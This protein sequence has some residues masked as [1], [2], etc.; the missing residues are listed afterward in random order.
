MMP[1][2]RAL[3]DFAAWWCQLWAE[4]LGKSATVG[5]T[6]VTALGATDQHS[7]IQL[8]NEG[9]N[10]KFVLFV[11]P[12]RFRGDPTIPSLFPGEA[13]CS[14]LEGKKLSTVMHALRNGTEEALTAN[15]RPNATVSIPEVNARTLGALLYTFEM[16]TAIAGALYGVNPFDQPGVEAGKRAAFSHLAREG[17]PAPPRRADDSRNSVSV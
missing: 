14:Y 7:Q 8:Y 9:P 13:T 11:A 12:E 17:Y 3:R 10:D 6:P 16:A 4:S 2:A 15:R 5:P 1:Y